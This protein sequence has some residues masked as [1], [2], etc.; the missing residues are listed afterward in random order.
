MQIA[1][2]IS[3]DSPARTSGNYALTTEGLQ[4]IKELQERYRGLRA[5]DLD[6]MN[7]SYS[8]VI[9]GDRNC[10]A[11]NEPQTS[12]PKNVSVT[13][14]EWTSFYNFYNDNE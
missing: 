14:A 10:L 5:D 3:S 6:P 4:T 13:E 9:C 2:V 8:C 11:H 7:P 1:K 12:C